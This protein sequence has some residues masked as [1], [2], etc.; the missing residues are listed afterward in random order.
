MNSWGLRCVGW[1]NLTVRFF[2]K[3]M[4]LVLLIITGSSGRKGEGKC[5]VQE[6]EFRSCTGALPEGSGVGSNG[7][8]IPE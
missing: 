6:E 1:S 8:D 4:N 3:L 5:G 2:P 7:H